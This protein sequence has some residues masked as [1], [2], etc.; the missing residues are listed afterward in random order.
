MSQYFDSHFSIRLFSFRKGRGVFDAHQAFKN[1]L[2]KSSSVWIATR[3]ISDYGNSISLKKLYPIIESY[4]SKPLHPNLYRILDQALSPNFTNAIGVQQKLNQ[5]IPSGS[6]LTP[7]LENLYL[8]QLDQTMD[9]ICTDDPSCF[10]AR[11][12]DDFIFACKDARK[13]SEAVTTMDSIVH[14]LELEYSPNKK[15]EFR[16]GIDQSYMEWLG[17]S[18]TAKGTISTRPKHF[19]PIYNKFIIGFKLFLKD[20]SEQNPNV[21][22]A[23]PSLKTAIHQY[24]NLSQHPDLIKLIQNKNDPTLTKMFDRNIRMYLVRWLARDF[25]IGKSEAWKKIRQLKIPS[26]NFQRRMRWKLQ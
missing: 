16:L 10:Y 2:K 22:D 13:F 1:F 23:M 12:G 24:L 9:Q 17:A 14:S 20:L 3:D 4:L 6:P 26:L 7:V 15:M 18:F 21:V 5:G 11:Y 25:K 19:K 8:M